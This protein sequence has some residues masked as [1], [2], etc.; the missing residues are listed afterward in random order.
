[1]FVCLIIGFKFAWGDLQPDC[2]DDWPYMSDDE[3]SF[4]TEF[5]V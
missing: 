5:P 4:S 2:L 1:V 3:G